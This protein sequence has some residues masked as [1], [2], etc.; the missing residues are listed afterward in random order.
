MQSPLSNMSNLGQRVIAGVIGACLMVGGIYFSQ[1]SYFVLFLLIMSLA[2]REFYTLVV[3]DGHKPLTNMGLAIGVLIYIT[4]FAQQQ[5]WVSADIWVLLLPLLGLVFLTKLYFIEDKPFTNIAYTFLGI[6]YVALPFSAMHVVAFSPTQSYSYQ[7]V[8]GTL[9]L[10]WSSDSGAY[11]A[12]SKFGKTRLF[13]RISPKKSWEGFAG[14]MALALLSAYI[15]SFFYNDLPLWQ[16]L[17]IAVIMVC[18]GT[19]GDLVESMLKRSIAI[20]DSGS[21]I[22]GHGGFLDR[23]D[24]LLIAAPVVS[25]FLTILRNIATF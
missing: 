11:F 17:V 1:W 24:G 21:V 5:Q 13:E 4:T 15:I 23:F 3:G 9:I 14:G 7:A 6:I 8:L 12:G 20:K 2:Q 18:I 16:W 10:L 25:A 22:P 19:Y